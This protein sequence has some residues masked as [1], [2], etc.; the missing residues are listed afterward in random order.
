MVE[1]KPPTIGALRQF[2]KSIEKEYGIQR[3][4][5]FGSLAR[6]KTN[7]NSDVD[8][9]IVSEKFK[10]LSHLKRSPPLHLAWKLRYPVDFL[11]YTPAEFDK[12]KKRVSIVRDAI[13]EGVEIA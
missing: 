12:L 10:G 6:G 13:R 7:E 11:C 3:M 2:K 9:I 4:L 1:R 5:L 8:L